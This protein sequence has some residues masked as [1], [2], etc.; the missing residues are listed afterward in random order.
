MTGETKLHQLSLG[1]V[2]FASYLSTQMNSCEIILE[3]CL[4]F[5]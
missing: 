1:Q 4:Y 2:C 3:I 5:T